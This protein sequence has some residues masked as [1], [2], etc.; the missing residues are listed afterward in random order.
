MSD[1]QPTE[2]MPPDPP[3]QPPRPRLTR[4]TSDSIIG[5]AAG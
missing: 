3:P 2:Q 4:S 1:E 5:G